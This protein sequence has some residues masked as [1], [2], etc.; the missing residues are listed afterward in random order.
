MKETSSHFQLKRCFADAF[1]GIVSVLRTEWNFRIHLAALIIV[2]ALGF[3]FDI[4]QG[5]WLAVIT[6][7][8][9]VIIAEVLN[10]ALEYLADA[11]HPEA[12][13][14]VGRAKDAAAGG[15]MIA[16][17]AASIVGAI[18][19]FPRIWEWVMNLSEK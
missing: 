4:S 10:T 13:E 18:V 14:G 8:A 3:V 11:V 9:L 12:D 6:C 17:V 1:R 19:F 7:S 15:V 2:I 5:E 16:A